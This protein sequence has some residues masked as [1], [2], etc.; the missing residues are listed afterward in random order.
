MESFCSIDFQ[1]KRQTHLHRSAAVGLSQLEEETSHGLC[2]ED[3][4]DLYPLRI[5]LF[6]QKLQDRSKYFWVAHENA[7]PEMIATIYQHK[8]IYSNL[9]S[10]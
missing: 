1:Y 10:C 6:I 8:W 7:E 2:R 3:S 9:S 5:Y 4:K